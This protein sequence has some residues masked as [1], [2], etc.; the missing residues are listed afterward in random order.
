VGHGYRADCIGS[1][2]V[3]K[4]MNK[5]DYFKRLGAGIST[6]GSYF[7]GILMTV[8]PTSPI[9]EA[10]GGAGIAVGMILFLGGALGVHMAAGKKP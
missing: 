1:C 10:I 7:M 5:A 8:P 6:G 9:S 3:E 2:S 4:E